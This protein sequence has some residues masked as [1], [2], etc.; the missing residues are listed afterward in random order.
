MEPHD[1][2]M[3]VL[4]AGL[5]WFGWFGFNAG[6]AVAANGLAASAFIVTNTAA[7][8][9]TLT[10]VGASYLHKR[11]VSVVGAACGAVAGLVAITPASGFVTPGGAILIGL[12]A[13]GLCYSA[14]LLRERVK[15][16]D[17]LDVF[18]VHGVGGVFGALATGVLATSAIQA[19]YKGLIDGNPGQVLTQLVA[20]VAT[21]AYAVVATFVIVKLVDVILGI[22]ISA[23][24]EELGID[25]ATHG[26][27]AYQS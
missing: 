7:A 10:W 18:A 9:A 22:R 2:P 13:G 4:G 23:K 26:E 21:I 14:T 1:V 20:V 5:L 16:D 15:V 8:A 3:T 17:A 11:K 24:D 12:A 6:S 25:L 19:S 27:V